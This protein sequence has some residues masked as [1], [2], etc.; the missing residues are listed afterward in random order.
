MRSKYGP[1]FGN[2]KTN[3]F[4]SKKEAKRAQELQLMEKIGL[5]S[6]LEYQVPFELIPKQEGERSVVYKA[7]FTYFEDKKLVVEDAKGFKTP[8]YVIKR[9]LLLWR[10]GI[11]IRET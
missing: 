2:K 1:K 11:R 9:K 10:Y 4:E 6:N 5:I 7:D 8:E 3:G